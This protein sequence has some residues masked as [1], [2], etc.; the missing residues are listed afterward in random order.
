MSAFNL[1]PEEWAYARRARARVRRWTYVVGVYAL[2]L[3]GAWV[4]AAGPA[5]GAARLAADLNT[6]RQELQR[7][8]ED[9]TRLSKQTQT[10]LKTVGE[11]ELIRDHPDWSGMLRLL[12]AMRGEGLVLDRVDLQSRPASPEST[13][14]RRAAPESPLQG[15]FT[16]VCSGIGR[17]RRDVA[18]FVRRLES[19]E[20]FDSVRLT[21]TRVNRFAGTADEMVSFG[22]TCTLLEPKR[23]GEARP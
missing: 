7:R 5:P 18:D 4:V 11:S 10:L 17:T 13:K 19:L 14:G 16:L 20:L 9:A 23:R 12:A 2:L 21:E 6:A 22:V 1:L 3:A 8:E 15:E